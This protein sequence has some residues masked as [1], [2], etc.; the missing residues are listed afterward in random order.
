M[1]FIGYMICKYFIQVWVV[2]MS[3]VPF[4]EV[5]IISF[6]L[7]DVICKKSL[8]TQGHKDFPLCSLLEA[9]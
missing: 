6:V 3:V 4:E 5:H 9:L 1:S 2:F 8:L 7:F